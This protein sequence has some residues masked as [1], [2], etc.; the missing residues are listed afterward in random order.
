MDAK[1]TAIAL[2][3]LFLLSGC[4]AVGV[5]SFAAEWIPIALLALLA[6]FLAISIIYMVSEALQLQAG[7]TWAKNELYQTAATAVILGITIVLWSFLN[8][9]VVPSVTGYTSGGAIG[10]SDMFDVSRIYLQNVEVMY[11]ARYVALNALSMQLGMWASVELY[12]MPVNTG[13]ILRIGQAFRA[14]FDFLRIVMNVVGIAIGLTEAQTA[15]LN[16]AQS[17]MMIIFLPIGIVLRSVPFTRGIGGALIATAIGFY[18]VYPLTF[19]MNNVIMEKHYAVVGPTATVNNLM[20]YMGKWLVNLGDGTGFA[21]LF[22]LVVFIVSSI[23]LLGLSQPFLVLEI[24]SSIFKTG[25]IYELVY[26][27]FIFAIILPILNIFFTLTFIREVS[28]LIGDDIN[29]AA[30]TRLI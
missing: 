14:I 21:N 13:F 7:Q 25:F 17:S 19:I 24:V 10:V 3:F 8:S 16:F 2:F 22:K 11:V 20:T 30:L 12:F 29:L 27:V 4:V 6:T 18:L 15:L 26:A 9:V 28:R 23:F 5:P 1:K